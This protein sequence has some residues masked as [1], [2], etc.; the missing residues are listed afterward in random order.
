[1]CYAHLLA[2]GPQSLTA[3]LRDAGVSGLIV[4]DLTLKQ[5]PPVLDACG[6]AGVALVPVITPPPT[7]RA[8]RAL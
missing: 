5:T 6:A 3:A 1:M 7:G 2:D 4:P 8:S